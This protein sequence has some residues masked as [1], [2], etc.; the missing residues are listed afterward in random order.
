[1]RVVIRT[2]FITTP[3]GNGF[4]SRII[5]SPSLRNF[6]DPGSAFPF[7]E[8]NMLT[9]HQNDQRMQRGLHAS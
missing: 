3:F 8:G 4:W 9:P 7:A 1:M 2:G 5:S 6:R